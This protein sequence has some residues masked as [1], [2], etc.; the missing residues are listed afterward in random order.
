MYIPAFTYLPHFQYSPFDLLLPL[1]ADQKDVDFDIDEDDEDCGEDEEK[2]VE[3]VAGRVV[4]TT[5]G[6]ARHDE[7]EEMEVDELAA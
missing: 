1:E 5:V 6:G 7:E 4:E 3:I 2:E